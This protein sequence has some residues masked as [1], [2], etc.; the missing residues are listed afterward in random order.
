[1]L[2]NQATGHFN[3]LLRSINDFLLLLVLPIDTNLRQHQFITTR[4]IIFNYK[5]QQ[6]FGDS[7]GL[8]FQL[9]VS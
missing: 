8:I 2:E 3:S 6:S 9:S 5:T 1:M 7:L 4:K